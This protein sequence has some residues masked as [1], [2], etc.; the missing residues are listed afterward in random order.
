MNILHIFAV[1]M[2]S[3]CNRENSMDLNANPV[4]LIVTQTPLDFPS[5]MLYSVC[6]HYFRM[7]I[8]NR[9]PMKR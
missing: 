8:E 7:D 6:L 2:N 4:V 1:E 9:I 3:K 5:S